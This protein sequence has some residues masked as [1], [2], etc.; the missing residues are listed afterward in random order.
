MPF[1]GSGTFNPKLTFVDN[2][3]ATAEDQNSQD[4]DIAAG[5]SN[6]MTRDGQGGATGNQNLNNHQINNLGAP[7]ASGDAVNLTTLQAV[8]PIGV[9]LDFTASG[10]PTNWAICQGQ[11]VSRTTYATLFGLIG[12][13]YGAGDGSTTFNIPNTQGR[14]VAAIDGTGT[15]LTSATMSPNGGTLGATGGAQ[16]YSLLTGDLAI[17]T[18]TASV[19]DTGHTH[20]YTTV[21]APTLSYAAGAGVNASNGGTGA[22]TGSSTTGISVTNANTGSG[23]AHLNVQP[24]ILL[25]KIIKLL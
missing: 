15:I 9:V 25:Q 10:A 24:T 3:P 22:T 7:V 13:A 21:A 1:N 2:S 4:A 23:N 18:H 11:A 5:L 14:V 6:C 16:T 17:H 12:T 19:T 20:T 8:L